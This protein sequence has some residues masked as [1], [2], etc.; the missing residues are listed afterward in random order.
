M[1]GLDY[2]RPEE[3]E[4]LPVLA[5]RSRW[6]EY[7]PL[8]EVGH[9]PAVVLLFATAS[10]GLILSE[11]IARVDGAAPPAMGRPACALIPQVTNSGRSA[12]SFGCCGAR[13]YLDSMSDG[14]AVW[15]LAGGKLE[16]YVNEIEAF[17][18][19]NMVLSRF[20]DQR[21]VDVESGSAPTVNQSLARS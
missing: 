7:A 10:Q 2:M 14:T 4:S 1:Q 12:A 20:H 16:L 18:K 21:R 13:A 19:A 5:G 9:P 8:A 3:I 17:A 11:A 15:G 6:I